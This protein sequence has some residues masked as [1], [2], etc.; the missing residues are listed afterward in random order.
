MGVVLLVLFLIVL[1]L[2]KRV[3][4]AATMGIATNCMARMRVCL[5]NK[6]NLRVLARMEI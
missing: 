4:A 1:P 5:H 3:P 6:S 2:L